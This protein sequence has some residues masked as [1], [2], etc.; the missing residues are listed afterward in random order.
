TR[1]AAV[2][3]SATNAHP[4]A[5]HGNGSV[6]TQYQPACCSPSSPVQI[7]SS[8][9]GPVVST[10]AACP[11]WNSSRATA[12]KVATPAERQPA[13]TDRRRPGQ[14]GGAPSPSAQLSGAVVGPSAEGGRRLPPDLDAPDPALG[15]AV[16]P[17]HE[18]AAR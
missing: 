10:T 16:P 1:C 11:S 8:I 2:M 5:G 17:Q 14:A 13:Q 3:N 7:S 18:G 12:P 15:S 6:R 4:G 9:S